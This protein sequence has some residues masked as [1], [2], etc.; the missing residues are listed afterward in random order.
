MAAV[1][2]RWR[3]VYHKRTL[4]SCDL[5]L[6]SLLLSVIVS[7]RGGL[8]RTGRQNGKT[9]AFI[10]IVTSVRNEFLGVLLWLL[11]ASHVLEGRRSRQNLMSQ[12][13]Q[14][15][16][17]AQRAREASA[18]LPVE[19]DTATCDGFGPL[20]RLADDHECQEPPGCGGSVHGQEGCRRNWMM[21]PVPPPR[22]WRRRWLSVLAT[23][24]G[25]HSP[26]GSPAHCSKYRSRCRL[27][28]LSVAHGNEDCRNSHSPPGDHHGVVVVV[29]GPVVV[30]VYPS[31]VAEPAKT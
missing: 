28:L 19:R 3:N 17:A 7:L 9:R 4:C 13:A 8:C 31:E 6:D 29:V 14:K 5:D 10:E 25:E 11:S 23:S 21:S 30:V 2:V 15:P 16:F 12:K 24:P 27:E 1:S 22:R 20:D 26:R 18:T